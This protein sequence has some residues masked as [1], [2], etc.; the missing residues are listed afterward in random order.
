MQ[1]RR[2]GETVAI[3][4]VWHGRLWA[5]RP[6]TVVR[7]EDDLLVLWCPGGTPWK[8]A[9]TP[10]GRAGPANRTDWYV[11]LLLRRDWVLVDDVWRTPTLWLLRAAEWR[12]VW[13]SLPAPAEGWQWYVNLQE[14]FV[15]TEAGIRATDLMLDVAVAS[16]G[17]W[18][19]K[20][21]R[22]FEALVAHGLVDA[23]TAGHVRAEAQ[24]SVEEIAR[25]APPFDGEW[26]AWRPDPAWPRPE[27]PHGW[28][29]P[30]ATDGPTS[31]A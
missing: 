17:S 27:L 28:E 29:L 22:D 20:D 4:E 25:R 26:L 3:Q 23:A 14:P 6:A 7:D 21:E 15:R 9:A 19:W 8:V 12:A 10:P 18:R 1:R 5:A 16:D 11:D 24:R 31:P 2:P 30:V 13:V